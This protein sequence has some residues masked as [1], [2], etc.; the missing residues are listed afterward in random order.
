MSETIAVCVDGSEQAD[1]AFE[2]AV[3]LT[4]GL[5]GRLVILTAVPFQKESTMAMAGAAAGYL[6]L[7]PATSE[8][9]VRFHT[10]LAE[11]MAERAAGKGVSEV[12]FEVLEGNPV[13]AIL[14]YLDMKPADILVVGARGLSRARRIFLGSVSSGLSLHAKCSVLVVRI[15]PTKAS[16]V[17][18]RSKGKKTKGGR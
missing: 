14:D 15:P 8:Q 1:A 13:D 16:E 18:E 12:G 6:P 5:K 4:L 7:P 3:R 11:R 10:D 2:M 9:A 17:N